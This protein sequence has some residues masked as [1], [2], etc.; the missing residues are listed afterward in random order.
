MPHLSVLT[1]VF[2]FFTLLIAPVIA[3]AESFTAYEIM[4][5]VDARDTGKTA[6][7]HNT[8]ILIDKRDRQRIRTL[9]FFSKDY[10]EVE[11][12][13]SFFLEPADVR[14]TA[15]LSHEWED[16]SREIDSWLYLPALQKVNRIA[17]ADRSSAFMG[18]DFTYS[19]IDGF[20]IDDFEY[21]LV[22]DSDPVDGVDCWVLESIPKTE[23]VVRKTGYTH[24]RFWVRK[25]NFMQ[26][27][28]IINVKKGKRIK[29]FMARDIELVDG[30]WIARK[31]QM[32]TTR[33]NKRQHSSLFIINDVTFNQELEDSIFEVQSMQRGS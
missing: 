25:D 17:A 32:V 22:N 30:I 4:Q 2:G 24:S 21:T 18:S 28:S 14:D 31:L 7:S 8:L 20:K 11:K 10:G 33:N 26:V 27:K 5:R 6:V 15:Y 23:A 19:D 9:K 12:R 29:F 1:G 13:I 3:T 16:E